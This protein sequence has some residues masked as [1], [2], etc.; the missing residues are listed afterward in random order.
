MFGVRDDLYGGQS[1]PQ[2]RFGHRQLAARLTPRAHKLLVHTETSESRVLLRPKLDSNLLAL[3]GQYPSQ[4]FQVFFRSS[5]TRTSLV[6][7]Q[8]IFFPG[9][10]SGCYGRT[11]LRESGFPLTLSALSPPPASRAWPHLVS[12]LLAHSVVEILKYILLVA[13]AQPLRMNSSCVDI[14]SRYRSS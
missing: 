2:I 5:S 13:I 4:D 1:K 6:F 9:M 8:F 11:S 12:S 10:A 14:T 3:Y 7:S